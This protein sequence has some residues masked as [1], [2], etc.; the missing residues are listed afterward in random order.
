MDRRPTGDQHAPGQAA[1][2]QRDRPAHGD[3]VLS[4]HVGQGC[5]A[6]AAY[7]RTVPPVKHATPKSVYCI[8]LHAQK[9]PGHVADI[10]PSDKVRYGDYLVRI[11]HCMECH[12]PLARGRLVASMEGSGGRSFK[13]PWG[14]A[15]SANITPDKETGL[16]NWTDAQIKTA[17][18]KGKR[19]DGSKLRPPMCFRCY[20]KMNDGDLD[21]V[22]ASL[23]AMKPI[24]KNRR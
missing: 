13:G 11:G 12:T 22:I 4:R 1:Q 18:Q 17:I 3:R 23:R 7:L 21:A 9:P 16:G 2:R 15:I 24:K 5:K 8:P 14:E 19:H 6:I 10:S 20:D